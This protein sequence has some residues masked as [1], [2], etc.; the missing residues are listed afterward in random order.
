MSAVL[1]DL[2]KVWARHLKLYAKS[3]L[4]QLPA[5]K[6]PD[7]PSQMPTCNI[8]ITVQQRVCAVVNTCE[9]CHETTGQLEESIHKV[10][11]TDDES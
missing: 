2:H 7:D 1:H 3:C 9:Y 4:G 11:A 5:V 6:Q 8:D 10:S